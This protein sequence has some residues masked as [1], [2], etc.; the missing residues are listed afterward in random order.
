[1]TDYFLGKKRWCRDI[2]QRIM[3]I[4]AR[5]TQG[6]PHMTYVE[7]F[8][9]MG[10]VAGALVPLLHPDALVCAS[11]ANGPLMRFW[12][13]LQTGALVV[14]DQVSHEQCV[15]LQTTRAEQTPLH[16]LIGYACSFMG[17]YFGGIRPQRYERN[18]KSVTRIA[19]TLNYRRRATRYTCAS[20]FDLPTP[21]NSIVYLDPP[22]ETASRETLARF[23]HCKDFDH[24]AFWA[25]AT[26]WAQPQ[27]NNAVFVSE[28]T[29]PPEWLVVW[30]QQYNIQHNIVGRHQ[31]ATRVERLFCYAPNNT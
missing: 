26:E 29:A 23:A 19:A 20:F 8:F 9:G 6:L 18:R 28:R 3:Y 10:H 13:A 12:R 2:A 7:P 17:R 31:V 21:R 30:E 24:G 11:D 16:V 4:V 25:R 1:M 15:A 27:H 22:Y 5:T 14:P